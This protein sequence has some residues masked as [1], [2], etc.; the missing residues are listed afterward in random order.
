M[1]HQKKTGSSV[2]NEKSQRKNT[3]SHGNA[4]KF[5][6]DDKIE[7]STSKDVRTNNS[8]D[9]VD[10]SIDMRASAMSLDK[11]ASIARDSIIAIRK[12]IE[13]STGEDSS[14][15]PTNEDVSSLRDSTN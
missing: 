7:R 10:V 1:G 12:M 4:R 2:N 9:I 8:E 6:K 11:I 15:E 5:F 13:T 3:L 14:V